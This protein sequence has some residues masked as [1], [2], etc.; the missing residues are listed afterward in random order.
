MG[1]RKVD[2]KIKKLRKDAV[3]PQ[4]AHVS[5]AGYDL[6][7]LGEHKRLDTGVVLYKTGLSLAAPMGYYFEIIPR[8]SIVKSG[9]IQANSLGIIDNGYRGELFVPLVKVDPSAPD[10][11][12]PKKIAQL[13]LR[14]MLTVEFIEVG[15]LND[16][17]R[18]EAG[19]GST[20]ASPYQF[21]PD[22]APGYNPPSIEFCNITLSEDEGIGEGPDEDGE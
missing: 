2:C 1:V 7:I 6:W 20:D 22:Y 3:I 9:Y 17:V 21:Y 14:E 18:G 12:F 13:V 11:E 16:T 8:S 10:I 19:Y 4:K 15:E 5:D